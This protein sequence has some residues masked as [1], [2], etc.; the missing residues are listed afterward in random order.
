MTGGHPRRHAG[1]V[2]ACNCETRGLKRENP[3]AI[4]LLLTFPTFLVA[5]DRV[6]ADNAWTR[7]DVET[8]Y[9]LYSEL[10]ARG[11]GD[12]TVLHRMALLNAWD[13]R[14]DEGLTLLDRAL[15]IDPVYEPALVDQARILGMAGRIGDA[16]GVLEPLLARRPGNPEAIA[17]RAQLSLWAGGYEE[18]LTL[19]DRLVQLTGD[20]S[21]YRIPRARGMAALER[22][23]DALALVDEAISVNPQDLEALQAK[24]EISALAGRSGKALDAYDRL[25]ASAMDPAPHRLARAQLLSDG[26][27][28]EEAILQLDQVLANQPNNLAALE[29]KGLNEAWSGR[30]QESVAT[31]D[32][33]ISLSP[34]PG[35]L[36]L[37]RARALFWD[38]RYAEALEAANLAVSN[39]PTDQEA[40]QLKAQAA[41]AAGRRDEA[42]AAYADVISRSPEP[43]QF[44]LARATLLGENQEYEAALDEARAAL[45]SQPDEV[46]ALEATARYAAA[47]QRYSE[48]IDAYDQL[49]ERSPEVAHRI[50]RA[51]VLAWDQRY[52]QAIAVVDDILQDE[53]ANMDALALRAEVA[54]WA[55][56]YSE[57][58]VTYD[59][60]LS[61]NPDMEN[62]RQRARV[63]VLDQQYQTAA[64]EYSRVLANDPS[65][66]DALVGLGR[67]LS[68]TAQYDSANVVY[69]RV[70]AADPTDLDARRGS[71]Q[72]ATWD[73]NVKGGEA[74]WRGVVETNPDDVQA[75]LGLSS[76][77]RIQGRNRAARDVLDRVE[78]LEPGNPAARDARAL[79]ERAIAASVSP[80]YSFV[81]DSD[82]NE[83]HTVALSASVQVSDP[84]ELRIGGSLRDLSQT[85]F[86]LDERVLTGQVSLNVRTTTGWSL[87]GGVGAWQP[88]S[89]DA[90]PIA[91]VTAG[92][93][94]P[95]WGVA[96]AS[97]SFQKTAYDVTALVSQ[98]RVDLNEIRL[99]GS[100]RMGPRAT[101]A[102]NVS[103]ANFDGT[104]GNTRILGGARLN[105]QVQPWLVMGPAMR[106]FSFEKD[107]DDGYWDPDSY[108]LVEAPLALA[109]AEGELIPRLEV[110]PGFQRIDD[111]MTSGWDFSIRLQGGIT[112]HAG[113]RRQLAVSGIWSR[114]GVQQ[115]SPSDE[116]DYEFRGVFVTFA[117]AF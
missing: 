58:L 76:N 16:L 99:D 19:F 17:V 13:G 56:N 45:S 50:S 108:V 39:D 98:N 104:E 41:D 71:A 92:L 114:S 11:S 94:S 90:D 44:H 7:G 28:Y 42:L 74:L 24:A 35:R 23:D 46:A 91:T 75:L 47:A 5:Q 67:A 49:V 52:D 55:G 20:A 113:S 87:S 12:V 110:S 54:T 3:I 103:G 115:L 97:L 70:L 78:T 21:P 25:I 112:Y 72:I 116:T 88:D 34:D 89:D 26:Q 1:P 9:E 57:S 60:I 27:R 4:W 68:W 86:G 73:G 95:P 59:R 48:S 105:V 85:N 93:S 80:S 64:D 81:T 43:A 77:L 117:W 14:Y 32:R 111:R 30:Y 69:G 101:L 22:Y 100:V 38:E 62:V 66:R 106:A 79:N 82:D 31:F 61:E 18:S 40:L 36:H 65:D 37:P 102:G 83:I 33:L 107:L 96:R 84:V 10:L 51:R 6:A 53:P 15:R 8:A 63:L 29:L 109:P 2:T